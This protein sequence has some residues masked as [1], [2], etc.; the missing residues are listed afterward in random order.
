MN[1]VLSML[2]AL[3]MILSLSAGTM[4]FAVGT[5]PK[6]AANRE[7]T[8]RVE[9]IDHNTRYPTDVV[10]YK[11]VG[12]TPKV[13]VVFYAGNPVDYRDYGTLLKRVASAGYLVISPECP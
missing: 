4:A 9:V 13:G 3:V 12:V 10:E 7:G 1:K 2:L 6:K 11:P 8:Y 5:S